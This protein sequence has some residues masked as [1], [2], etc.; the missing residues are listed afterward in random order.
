MVSK[1]YVISAVSKSFVGGLA[2]KALFLMSEH[3]TQMA[4]KAE[5]TANAAAGLNTL[6]SWYSNKTGLWDSTGWWNSAN[7]LT[8]LGDFASLG[9]VNQ[10]GLNIPD[11]IQNTYEQARKS[12]FLPIDLGDGPHFLARLV[13]SSSS[14]SSQ[15][16]PTGV[17]PAKRWPKRQIPEPYSF[18]IG[19][20]LPRH[21]QT[22]CTCLFPT[23]LTARPGTT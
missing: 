12:W 8:V 1:S 13:V 20:P 19:S 3:A 18:P 10:N 21:A 14:G 17:V 16:G 5:Y 9:F 15:A 23:S 22:R 6:Q 7:C 11:I 2:S 4:D